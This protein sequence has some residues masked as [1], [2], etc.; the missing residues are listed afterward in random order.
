M[1]IEQLNK[2]QIILLTL[3]VSFVTSIATGIVTVSLV[4][5]APPGITQTVSRIVERTVEK[6][7]PDAAGN[8]GASVITTT[9][10]TVIVK[11]DDLVSQSI[12]TVQKS[13]IRIVPKDV[14]GAPVLA[15]GVIV[16]AKG[17]AVTDRAALTGGLAFEAILPS[18]ERVPVSVRGSA[19]GSAV[20]VLD[21]TMTAAS[22]TKLT[23]AVFSSVSDL[24]LGQTVI[25]LGGKTRDAV[26]E[27][28]VA[29]LP[30]SAATSGRNQY[31]E[32]SVDSSVPGG[33]L[34]TLFGEIIGMTTTDSLA[35]GPEL[36]ATSGAVKAA[37]A[38]AK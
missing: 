5:Q 16:D 36:Y 31:L 8:Q 18:G 13:I 14:E 11:E 21:L 24:K 22:T 30:D 29:S 20:A 7:V 10:K 23:P 32:A 33:V 37:L 28:V 25:R 38:P 15:R 6:V 12:A 1:D 2:T 4:N 9:E 3:L 35:L 34:I 19:D 27:G 26:A 17:V